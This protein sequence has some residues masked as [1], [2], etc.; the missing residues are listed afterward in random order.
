[1]SSRQKLLES[2]SS[3]FDETDENEAENAEDP[4]Q[5]DAAEQERK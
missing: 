1:M 3:G 2:L 4:Y 5:R